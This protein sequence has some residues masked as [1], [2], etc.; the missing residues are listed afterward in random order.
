MRIWKIVQVEFLTPINSFVLVEASKMFQFKS[1]TTRLGTTVA[2]HAGSVSV[3]E[4]LLLLLDPVQPLQ[5]GSCF[6]ANVRYFLAFSSAGSGDAFPSTLDEESFSSG[7]NDLVPA[8]VKGDG[9]VTEAD[10]LLVGWKCCTSLV[11]LKFDVAK[12]II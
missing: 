10:S 8:K 11:T 7:G 12:T 6:S 1:I 3:V 9:S 5:L 4:L 2:G